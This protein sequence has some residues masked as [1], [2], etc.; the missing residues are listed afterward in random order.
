MEF[1]DDYV[2]HAPLN[3]DAF[4]SDSSE[5]HTNPISY[6]TEKCTVEKKIMPYL[7]KKNRRNDYKSL[8]YH[9]EGIGAMGKAI[10]KSEN[11]FTNMFYSGKKAPIC[12]GNNL[13]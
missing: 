5:V 3:D 10:T 2:G 13:R 1:L 11:E 12:G 4:A 6:I 9:Y 8:K 7:S